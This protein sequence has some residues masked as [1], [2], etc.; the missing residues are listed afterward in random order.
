MDNDI[1]IN[2]KDQGVELF[3]IGILSLLM[4]LFKLD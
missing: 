2:D 4:R 3:L 1:L